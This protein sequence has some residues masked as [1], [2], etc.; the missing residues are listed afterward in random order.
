[1]SNIEP[2][3]RSVHRDGLVLHDPL[4]VGG[5]KE[6]YARSRHPYRNR[7]AIEVGSMLTHPKVWR[8]EHREKFSLGATRHTKIAK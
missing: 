7:L 4:N 5:L 3:R 1:M 6:S 2:K 8:R